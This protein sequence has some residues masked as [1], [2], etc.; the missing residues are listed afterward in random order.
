MIDIRNTN[1]TV[2]VRA[3]MGFVIATIALIAALVAW[4]WELRG[5]LMHGE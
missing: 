1:P 3:H 2:L 5:V 4:G